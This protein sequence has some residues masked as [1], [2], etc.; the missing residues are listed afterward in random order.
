MPTKEIVE[1]E[2]SLYMN[3]LLPYC[4]NGFVNFSDFNITEGE[5][6]TKTE[7]KEG[8]IIFNVDYPLAIRKGDSSDIIKE[9]KNIKITADVL[10]IY[11]II[12]TIINDQ[13]RR[14]NEGICLSCIYEIASK[15]DLI[16]DMASSE[17]GII[18]T[19]R[20]ENQIIKGATLEWRFANKYE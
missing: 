5:I 7:I 2:I 18:F 1:R 15:N 3:S 4:T 6:N 19:V 20:D 10:S 11:N 17:E 12:G 14:G 13:V 16:I 9:F 8:E